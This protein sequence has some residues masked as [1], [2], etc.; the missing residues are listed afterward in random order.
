MK[1]C[2][3]TASLKRTWS[4]LFSQDPGMDKKER[5]LRFWCSILALIMAAFGLWCNVVL[6]KDLGFLYVLASLTAGMIAVGVFHTKHK[7]H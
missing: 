2:S 5:L 3:I 6:G 4:T 1:N 7:K